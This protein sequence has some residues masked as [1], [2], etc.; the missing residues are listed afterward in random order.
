MKKTIF[1]YTC[2]GMIVGLMLAYLTYFG[3]SITSGEKFCVIC[4]EMDPMVMA[5]KDDVHG[6]DRKSVV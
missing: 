6:G 3:L 4:H 5:Y 1:I 2:V